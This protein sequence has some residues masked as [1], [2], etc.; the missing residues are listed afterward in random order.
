MSRHKF[1]VVTDFD[2]TVT[3]F[4]IGDHVALKF[5]LASRAEVLAS[6]NEGASVSQWMKNVYARK[7]VPGP[8]RIAA[9]VRKEAAPRAGFLALASYCRRNRIPLEIASGGLDVY[10][11][12]LLSFW[13][14]TRQVKLNCGRAVFK[15]SAYSV[16]YPFSD[17]HTLDR[18]KQSRVK[19]LQKMGYKVVFCGDG[20]SDYSAA[21]SAD[22]V[23]A[24]YKLYRHCRLKGVPAHSLRDFNGA[25][26]LLSGACAAKAAR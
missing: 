7:G 10:I 19:R 8:R 13:G 2:G 9:F 17:S 11:K 26:R 20:T 15:K 18:H 12:P 22:Y 24:R 1:A 3:S 4:D 5:R 16:S 6:Y 23:Y 14:L 21:A 25:L